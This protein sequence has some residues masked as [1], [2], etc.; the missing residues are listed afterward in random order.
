MAA[1]SEPGAGLGQCVGGQHLARSEARE[2][3][4]LLLLRAGELEPERAEL[5]HRE[6]EPTRRA[7]LRDLLDRDKGEQR[8]GAG[9]SVLLVEEEPEDAVLAIELDD[10][11]RELVRLV[12]LGSTRRDAVAGDRAHEVAD[13]E[14]LGGQ[15]LPGH[16]RSLGEPYGAL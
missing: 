14:L 12:D 9:A 13:L 7:D 5:L 3:A 15:R 11:P 10:V 8:P 16:A 4:A 6:D 2:E 1:E